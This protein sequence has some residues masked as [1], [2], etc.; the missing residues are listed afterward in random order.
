[1]PVAPPRLCSCGNIVPSGERCAC[2]IAG[3]RA[4]NARHDRRRPSSAARGYNHEWRKARAAYLLGH[5]YC[6]HPGCNAPA[7]H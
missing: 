4:R 3:D 1:M 2:Q 7:T 6:T 5:P